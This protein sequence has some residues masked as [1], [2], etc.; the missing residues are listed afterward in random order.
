[1]RKKLFIITLIFC[2]LGFALAQQRTIQ[3]KIADSNGATVVGATVLLKGTD[4][5]TTTDSDG[6]YVLNIPTGPATLVVSYIGFLTQEI[7]VGTSN[8]IDVTF[9]DDTKTLGEVVVTALGISRN[10]NE[11]PYSAQKLDGSETSK[12]RDNNIVNSLSGKIAG[13]NIKRNNNLGGSTNIVLRGTKSLTGNNQALFIVDGVPID[14]AN[15][16]TSRQIQGGGGYDYGSAAADINADDVESVT[17]LKGAAATALYGSRASNG[18]ILITTKSKSKGLG[19]TVNLGMNVGN[20]DKSTFAKYQ[21]KYGQG[22]GAY[23][24][25]PA[26]FF[27]YRDIDGDG[28][29]DL[30]TP[31]SEDASWGAKFDASKQVYQW[32]AFDPTSSNFGK[33]RPWVAAA[34]GP[35]SIFEQSI[36]T[37][38]GISIDGGNDKSF[39]KLGYTHSG[40]KGI[41]PNSRI[42]KNMVNLGGSYN[43][44]DNL[45]VFSNINFTS[46]EAVGR[47]GSGYESRNLMTNFRQW[48]PV[49]V[50]VQ[51]QKAA[52]ERNKQNTTWNWVDPTDLHPIYWDN[53]YWTRHENYQNDSRNRYFGHLGATYGITKWLDLTG[54]VSLDQY[55]EVQEERFAV[56]SID[57]SKYSR[58][59]RNFREIN[60]DFLAQ[61]KPFNTFNDHLAIDFLVGSNSRR[62]TTSSINA[63]TN[64]GLVVPK[65]YSLGNSKNPLEAPV[66]REEALEVNGVFAKLGLVFNKWAVLDLTMRRDQASTLPSENNSYNYPSASLGLIFSNLIGENK[67]MDFGKVRL[68]YAEVSNTAP[69]LSVFDTYNFETPFG[70]AGVASVSN[71]KN[72]SNLKP[73]RSKSSEVGL[74][75]RFLSG[76]LG[77]D[78]TLYK[79]NTIDQILPASISRATGYA[80]KFINAGNVE[81]TGVELSVF[82]RPIHTANFDWKMDIN[83]A[84]N[85]NKVLDLGGIDNL[86]LASFQGG[87]SI[88]AALGEP[89]GTI[90]GGNFVY[91]DNGQK[92][93][94]ANGFYSQ[95]ATS[96][97]IIGNI[98]PDWSGGINNTLRYKNLTFSFLIDTRQGGQLFSLDL[99]YGLATGSYPETAGLNDLGNEVRA[100]LTEGGGLI[101]AGVTSDGTANTKRVS[102]VNFG[103]YG[104]RRN[105]AAAFIYDASFVKLREMNLSYDIPTKG[106]FRNTIKGLQLG[107]YGRNLWI[108]K[109]NLPHADPEDGLSSGNIQGHQG[110]VYPTTKVIGANLKIRF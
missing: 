97:E 62:T 64:G 52:Y 24:E 3:G 84:R 76:L 23:Y 99:F 80:S 14:N 65:T 103:S 46:T 10:K 94:G 87:I 83:W 66:E 16:N 12:M 9:E 49:N 100:P 27:L 107:L 106:L 86:Q 35:A 108:I 6:N 90:R 93:V 54:R 53:P 2:N 91:H 4:K 88:N 17:V 70:N 104:Y 69:P 95:S 28:K 61:V 33:P 40:D 79:I 22:Y 71:T 25:D 68:N 85:R 36:G 109:K 31:M 29:E 11:L 21:D 1:M 58:F 77:F 96:N 26:G 56:G 72:N 34:N 105:P 92:I 50:D 43:L 5:G 19:V 47:Y 38:N 32:D 44:T 78:A 89:Y 48:W 20:F 42:D 15:T 102:A 74:E 51:E 73:E 60:Y 98:N 82:I 37:S 81:N 101:F 45:K 8:V 30:V 75:M 110:G 57:V 7:P 39:F 55:N 18:V 67:F 63:T 13:L 41:M 59:N